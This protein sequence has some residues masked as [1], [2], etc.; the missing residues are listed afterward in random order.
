MNAAPCWSP[1]CPVRAATPS[2]ARPKPC[3][4]CEH[5]PSQRVG[6]G[7]DRTAVKKGLPV[8]CEYSE[9]A[10][11]P[12]LVAS[13]FTS[14]DFGSL[15]SMSLEMH[16]TKSWESADPTRLGRNSFPFGDPPEASDEDASRVTQ[17]TQR[18][19]ST[20]D[21]RSAI[22]MLVSCSQVDFCLQ[23]DEMSSRRVAS[24]L[25]S[26]GLQLQLHLSSFPRLTVTKRTAKISSGAF[27]MSPCPLLEHLSLGRLQPSACSSSCSP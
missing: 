27:S 2:A 16:V 1:F 6:T 26:G 24:A 21:Y 23:K 7:V 11:S 4:Y 5:T 3:G 17:Q 13:C 20:P 10:L 9:P 19:I 22:S 8:N 12:L 15:E 18:C 14:C 25:L